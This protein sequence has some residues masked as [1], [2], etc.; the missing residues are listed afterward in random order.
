MSEVVERIKQYL[1]KRLGDIHIGKTNHDNELEWI[2]IK[3]ELESC[4]HWYMYDIYSVK[5]DFKL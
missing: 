5:I 4:R 3:D 2:D 1:G